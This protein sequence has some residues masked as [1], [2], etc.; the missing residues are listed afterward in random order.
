MDAETLVTAGSAILAALSGVS[1]YSDLRQARKYPPMAHWSCRT[2]K[3]CS[4]LSYCSSFFFLLL[5]WIGHFIVQQCFWSKKHSGS[6]RTIVNYFLNKIVYFK[7][8][9]GCDRV[10]QFRWRRDAFLCAS[11]EMPSRKACAF[12]FWYRLSWYSVQKFWIRMA[13][14][15]YSSLSRL[16]W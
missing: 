9:T 4:L 8:Q 3:A 5:F 1:V 10:W 7:E 13:A 14:V 6:R 11:W 15:G 12:V 2:N 16:T